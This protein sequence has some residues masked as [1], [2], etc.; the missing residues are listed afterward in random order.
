MAEAEVGSTQKI[1]EN[2]ATNF[3]EWMSNLPEHLHY[4][5]IN[6]LAIPGKY[7]C[8]EDVCFSQYS[9]FVGR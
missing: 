7:M 3:S 2:G 6:C 4:V 1:G 5:P 9:I 8:L